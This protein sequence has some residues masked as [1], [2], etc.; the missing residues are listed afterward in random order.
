MRGRTLVMTALTLSVGL[1]PTVAAH[2]ASTA[3][4]RIVDKY[5]RGKVQVNVDETSHTL[6]YG[7][8]TAYFDVT[9]DPMGNDGVTVTSLRY[10]GCGMGDAGNYFN[11]GH[12]YRVVVYHP[13]G[14]R[15]QQPDGSWVPGPAFRV[16]KVS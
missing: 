5:N 7:H 10:S 14:D 4:V 15:C 8:R 3:K 2:A 9:P 13:K 6:A 11:P 12:A 1:A 16:V